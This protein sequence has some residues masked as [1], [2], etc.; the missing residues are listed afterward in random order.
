[1]RLSQQLAA[2]AA[3]LEGRADDAATRME[4]FGAQAEGPDARRL[5]IY[6]RF[7]RTHR[8]EALEGVFVAVKK[9]VEATQG[10]DGWRALFEAYFRAHPMHHVEINENGVH[11]AAYLATRGD[12]PPWLSAVA[13]VE[14]W[15]WMAFVAP[16]DAPGGAPRLSASVEVRPL[17]WDVDAWLDAEQRG[18]PEAREQL[19]VFWRDRDLDSRRGVVTPIELVVMK[20]VS[21][22]VTAPPPGVD[23]EEFA[24]TLADLTKAGIVVP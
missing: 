9:Y 18:E 6:A 17:S 19:I 4:L 24:L 11:F 1:M 12:L 22:G 16:E 3:L 5:A 2:F 23:A 20:A 14:W 21:E 10:P 7:C 15:D 8:A 13:E